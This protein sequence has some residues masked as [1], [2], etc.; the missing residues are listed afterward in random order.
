MKF[1]L[2]LLIFSFFYF[3]YFFKNV[4]SITQV[5]VLVLHK[6]YSTFICSRLTFFVYFC[7][8]LLRHGC[9]VGVH[10]QYHLHKMNSFF[11]LCLKKKSD[12]GYVDS[13]FNNLSESID[14]LHVCELLIVL[15]LFIY[16][17]I[18]V[19]YTLFSFNQDI[20]RFDLMSKIVHHNVNKNTNISNV[21][22][23]VIFLMKVLCN[24]V[25]AMGVVLRMFI[26]K[27]MT[28][29]VVDFIYLI[30]KIIWT[31]MIK[32]SR[33]LLVMDLKIMYDIWL[34]WRVF[35]NCEIF[36]IGINIIIILILNILIFSCS[37][38][39]TDKVCKWNHD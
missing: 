4:I 3:H 20:V 17:S 5:L 37:F 26:I 11:F 35:I 18:S 21:I 24:F 2:W 10:F 29:N 28:T 12:L 30:K 33:F 25:K 23:G 8:V 36:I 7:L 9:F 31:Y 39:Y 32:V 14:F 6:K 19:G 15:F 34:I 27:S 22:F 38:P 13:T 16:I 1:T